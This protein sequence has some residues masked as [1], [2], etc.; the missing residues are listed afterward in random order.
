MEKNVLISNYN[1]DGKVC[2]V[3]GSNA[4]IGK[5]TALG[6]AESGATVVMVCRNQGRGEA[7]RDEIR[8]RSGS[9]TVDLMQADLSSQKSI[10]RFV[11]EFKNDYEQLHVLINNA[12]NFDHTLKEPVLTEEGV[13]PSRRKRWPRPTFTWL[14]PQR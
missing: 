2:I 9:K 8:A 6:L 5:R 14:P 7:A 11:A 3:T 4:G 10:R 12:A 13:S 1:M